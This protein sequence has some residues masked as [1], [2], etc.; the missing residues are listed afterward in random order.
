MTALRFAVFGTGWWSN[1]QI[2]AWFEVGGVEL[3]ALYN[4]TVS[5]ADKVAR[6]YGIPHVYGDPEELFRN[7]RLDFVDLIVGNDVHLP[8]VELA[9]KYRVPVICQKPMAPLWDA[10]QKMVQ[11]CKEAGVPFFIHENL[12]WQA[13]VREVKHLLD[14]GVIGQPYRARV[15]IVGYSALEYADQPFLKE[16]AQLIMMDM[17]SHVLDTARYLFGEAQSLYCQHRRTRQDIR[18]E[19][20]ATVLLNMGEVICSCEMSNATRTAWGHYPDVNI[21]IEGAQGS[22]ELSPDYW[23]KVATDDGVTARRIE[24]PCYAWMRCDQPHWHASIVSCHADLLKAIRAGDQHMAETNA[25]DN[26]KTMQL[27]F[28]AYESAADNRVMMLD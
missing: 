5:R 12:R 10:C 28:K 19:D 4:R 15:Q 18:G 13:P 9:A 8:M 27:I 21:F 26:L 17:G 24:A 16:L 22:I 7:E 20:V 14:S 6:H 1:Y 11:V 25:D 3:V 23:V 2:P